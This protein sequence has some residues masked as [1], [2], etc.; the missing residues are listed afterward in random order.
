M[1]GPL[2]VIADGS[3][4]GASPGLGGFATAL[5]APGP[6]MGSSDPKLSAMSLGGSG[7][8]WGDVE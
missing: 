4:K 7:Y 2:A 6:G 8:P 1:G 5:W 3:C